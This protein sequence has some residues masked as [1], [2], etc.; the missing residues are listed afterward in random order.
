MSSSNSAVTYTSISSKDVPLW[1]IRFFGM[2][3]LDSPEAALQYLIQT[4]PVPLD[5][6]IPLE[7]EHVLPT[8]EQPLPLVVL[9]IV[10]SPGYVVE[11]DPEEDPEEYE[12]DESKDGSVDYPIVGPSRGKSL[13]LRV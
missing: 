7:D 11:S 6:Y 13:T 1:G 12:D 10:E 9:P 8:E 5:E 4:P 3:Q 2:E